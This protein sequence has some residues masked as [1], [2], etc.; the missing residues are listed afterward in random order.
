MLLLPHRRETALQC[1]LLAG[2][3]QILMTYFPLV[4]NLLFRKFTLEL[5]VLRLETLLG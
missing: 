3:T 4:D 2:K 5:S 1:D